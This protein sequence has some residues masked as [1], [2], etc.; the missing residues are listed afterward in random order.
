MR[1]NLKHL[2]LV[3]C[4]LSR[5][6]IKGDQAK[7]VGMY[8]SDTIPELQA[9]RHTLLFGGK[10]SMKVFSLTTATRYWR[11][12]NILKGSSSCVG[13][14]ITSPGLL[15][16][17]RSRDYEVR[18]LPFR[19]FFMLWCWGKF[20][21][22]GWAVMSPVLHWPFGQAGSCVAWSQILGGFSISL[23]ASCSIPALEMRCLKDCIHFMLP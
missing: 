9:R 6:T 8:H 17:Y 13:F 5:S 11:R 15:A 1:Q 22:D 18:K 23:V 16:K 4:F 10:V 14:L 19:Y 2:C 21:I 7:G 12:L 3:H 20:A